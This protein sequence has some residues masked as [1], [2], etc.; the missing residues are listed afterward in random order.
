[1]E[2]NTSFNDLLELL[3]IDRGSI[4]RLSMRDK[5]E[6]IRDKVAAFSPSYDEITYERGLEVMVPA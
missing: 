6:S 4:K 1:L 5:I 3:N 2:E